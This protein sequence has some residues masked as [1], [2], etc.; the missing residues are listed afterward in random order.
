MSTETAIIASDTAPVRELLTDGE[1]ARLVD[2][3]DG[4]ALVTE[5]SALL[6]NPAERAR[7]GA[8]ARAHVVENYDLQA[9]CLP[10]QLEWVTEL[11]ALPPRAM[12]AP[13][14]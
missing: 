5:I 11:A 7:L 1:T 13:C 6:D 10:K 14:A 8:N 4:S 3:F 12:G 9:A 2:F